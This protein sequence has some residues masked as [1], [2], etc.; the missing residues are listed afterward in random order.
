[1]LFLSGAAGA[2]CAIPVG[3]ALD[4]LLYFSGIQTPWNITTTFKALAI[5]IGFAL[6]AYFWLSDDGP[7][8]VGRGLI[9][10]RSR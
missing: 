1:M 9:K 10:D 5:L 6:F 4:R 8:R 2:T 3:F 7:P